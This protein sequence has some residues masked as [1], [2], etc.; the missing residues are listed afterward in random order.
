M[1]NYEKG[2]STGK[3]T[4][5]D[6]ASWHPKSWVVG[7]QWGDAATAFDWNQLQTRRA[8]VGTVGTEPVLL[9]IA[10]NDVSFRAWSRRVDG[11]TLTFSCANRQLVDQQTGSV[12]TWRGTCVAGTLKG[13]QLAFIPQAYQEFWH[14]W[15]SFHPQTKRA[16]A[17]AD[18]PTS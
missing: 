9:T 17:V 14:S 10:P 13:H 8:L 2:L 7:L 12:W 1:K 5:R 6:S 4:R 11:K 15:R 16:L 3:L 18:R